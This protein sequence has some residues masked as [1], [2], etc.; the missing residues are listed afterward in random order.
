MSHPVQRAPA[1]WATKS[2]CYWLL[3]NLSKLPEGIYDP[4]EASSPELM[5]LGKDGKAGQFKG[6]LGIIMI[7]RYSDTPVGRFDFLGTS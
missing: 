1:P 3:F 5:D 6:G 2:E 7:V 4:L